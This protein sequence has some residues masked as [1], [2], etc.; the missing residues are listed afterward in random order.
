M[1]LFATLSAYA[2]DHALIAIP[3]IEPTQSDKVTGSGST[4]RTL[5]SPAEETGKRW[6]ALSLT[7]AAGAKILYQCLVKTDLFNPAVVDV[8]VQDMPDLDRLIV[9]LPCFN[10]QVPG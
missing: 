5:P 8:P 6:I 7:D 9:D 3:L 1:V 10:V 2:I 4:I